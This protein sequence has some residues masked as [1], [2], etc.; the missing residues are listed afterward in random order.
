MCLKGFIKGMIIMRL[1]TVL[2][3]CFFLV[4]SSSFAEKG[5]KISLAAL[6]QVGKTLSYDPAYVSLAYPMGDLPI[7]RGVCTDVV[8]R[9]LRKVGLDLQQLVHEDMKRSFNKYP[10][11]WGLRST[12][13]NI[14]HRRVPNLQCFFKRK[15]WSLVISQKAE[16]Y[17]SG[18]I[19]TWK[20]SNGLDHTGVVFLR[21]V[22]GKKRPMI[23]HNVGSGAQ[24]EDCLFSWKITGHY[25]VK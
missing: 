1:S 4:T 20:F 25:R 22:K 6:S 19:V 8:I 14:D 15:G 17:K 10:K 16:A 18:D 24:L 9:S 3:L 12:D 21:R 11:N 5:R 13:R 7:E 23:I 2:L